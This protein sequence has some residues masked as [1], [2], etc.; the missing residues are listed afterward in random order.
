MDRGVVRLDSFQDLWPTG[1][2]NPAADLFEAETVLGQ[3]ALHISAEILEYH[4]R[5][6][7]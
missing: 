4:L 3:E 6:L 5:D 1:V 2:K 7:W